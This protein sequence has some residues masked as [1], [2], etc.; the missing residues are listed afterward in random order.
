METGIH[1]LQRTNR[2]D[3][4]VVGKRIALVH[5]WSNNFERK[6]WLEISLY[7]TVLDTYTLHTTLHFNNRLEITPSLSETL[8]FNSAEQVVSFVRSMKEDLRSLCDRL[9]AK[10]ACRDTRLNFCLIDPPKVDLTSEERQYWLETFRN[11]GSH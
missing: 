6:D 9:L 2:G 1:T 3:I 7:K 11:V 4:E 5:N 8:T 10:A